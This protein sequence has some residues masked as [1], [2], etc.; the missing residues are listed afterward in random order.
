MTDRPGPS[1]VL[2]TEGARA[3]KV[4]VSAS[5]VQTGP[6]HDRGS[7]QARPHG[8]ASAGGGQKSR[9]GDRRG[10]GAANAGRRDRAEQQHRGERERQHRSRESGRPRGENRRGGKDDGWNGKSGEGDRGFRSGERRG[11]FRRSDRNDRGERDRRRF[12]NEDP[13]AG[14]GGTRRSSRGTGGAPGRAGAPGGRPKGAKKEAPASASVQTKERLTAPPLPE[15]ADANLLDAEVRRELGSL[16][17]SLAD[18]VAQHLVAAG[19]LVDEDPEQAL[20][21]ARFAR[22]KAARIGVVREA[23]G[24][25]AYHAGE[26]AEALSELRAARRMSG[27]PGH[28]AVIADCERALG[29]PERALEVARSP[30]V[31]ELGEAE[32]IELKIVAAGARRDMGQLEAA[33]VMLQGPELDPSRPRPWSARLFYAYA[34]NLAAAGRREEAVRWF[35]HAAEADLDEE[36]DAE[37]RARELA[38][39]LASPDEANVDPGQNTA[40]RDPEVHPPSDREAEETTSPDAHHAERPVPAA[41]TSEEGTGQS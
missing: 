4:S 40:Q 33:V 26:W 32:R 22:S 39:E 34:D 29:R 10:R 27:G 5:A 16:P 36:T 1:L 9:A 37:E 38:E 17:R 23:T 13:R 19:Q 14:R 8:E 12:R 2:A 24:L 28:L 3:R 21:H 25:T 11:G 18:L 20:L 6:D 35:L 15:G 30:E 7:G 41:P 31:K